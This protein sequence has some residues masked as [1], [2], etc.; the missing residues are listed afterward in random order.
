MLI[1]LSSLRAEYL[2]L[3]NNFPI[4]DSDNIITPDVPINNLEAN[5]QIIS[6]VNLNSE[7][8]SSGSEGATIKCFW[9]ETDNFALFNIK[10][11]ETE[12]DEDRSFKNSRGDTFY[13]NFCSDASHTCNGNSGLFVKY[14]KG[15]EKNCKLL[16][17]SSDNPNQFSL[18]DESNVEKGIKVEF[19]SGE[20]CNDTANYRVTWN[21][22][23]DEK[24]EDKTINI[25]SK[26]DFNSS[27]KCEYKI[28][29]K[30]R[31]ACPNLNF[32]AVYKFL[33]ENKFVTGT[34]LVILGLIEVFLGYKFLPV[35]VF[36]ISVL[37]VTS[38]VFVLV[39][40]FIAVS[41]KQVVV[42]IVLGTGAAAG[43][44]LGIFL[45][46]YKKVFFGILG[47]L[48]GLI[49][50]NVFYVLILRFVDWSPTAIYWIT[51][52]GCIIIFAL[53]T[54]LLS[55]FFVIIA[56]SIIG[57]YAVIR[58]A[59]LYFGG[60]PEE[61]YIIDC[62]SNGEKEELKHLFKAPF[63]IYIASFIVLSVIG[64]IVQFKTNKEEK[65][66]D[67]E[68]NEESGKQESMI[69][70]DEQGKKLTKKKSIWDNL[71]S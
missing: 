69:T 27:S 9:L 4:V 54:I 36:I 6:K 66:E 71:K 16:S 26:S 50:G 56:T 51:L 57:A 62:I 21:I 35:T 34:I 2:H 59:S 43:I 67:E 10:G 11:L 55:K 64:V 47:G 40:Q 44:I 13:Y 53:L 65:K 70:V 41:V 49:L 23:C 14:P 1:S 58:G 19:N 37:A 12:S 24:G 32:Y 38:L 52:V 46:K 29:A 63:Y 30:S 39:F 3:R 7:D 48:L 17:E 31:E 20:P 18:L 61:S 42:W 68:N 45:A 60:F 8:E 22:Y 5:T 15:E 25:L 33:K 28:N